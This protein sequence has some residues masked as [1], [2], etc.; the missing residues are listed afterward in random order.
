MDLL[1]DLSENDLRLV[2]TYMVRPFLNPLMCYGLVIKMAMLADAV[3]PGSEASETHTALKVL[4]M[5]HIAFSNPKKCPARTEE[6]LTSFLD[7]VETFFMTKPERTDPLVILQ[8]TKMSPQKKE[9]ILKCVKACRYTYSLPLR[10]VTQAASTSLKNAQKRAP[11]D[12]ALDT[13]KVETPVKKARNGEELPV[14]KTAWEIFEGLMTTKT[15]D[16]LY[17]QVEGLLAQKN[18]DPE[19]LH[20][21]LFHILQRLTELKNPTASVEMRVQEQQA[22][23]ER[24]KNERVQVELANATFEREFMDLYE[25]LEKEKVQLK[26]T[27]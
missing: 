20:K 7:S 26:G 25:L 10:E 15:S 24:A 5:K 17:A 6:N 22:Q 27:L 23:L 4:I 2:L 11:A 19:A 12:A 8:A 13:P 9:R 1:N 16:E 21:V 3:K 14:P 18:R